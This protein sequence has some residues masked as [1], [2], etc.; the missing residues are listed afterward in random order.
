M[1]STGDI[2]DTFSFWAYFCFVKT[3]FL[4]IFVLKSELLLHHRVERIKN[5]LKESGK[6]ADKDRFMNLPEILPIYYPEGWQDPF[7]INA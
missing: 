7:R 5:E 4:A 2:S 3:V 6:A 1:A